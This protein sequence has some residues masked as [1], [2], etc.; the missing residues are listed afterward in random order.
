MKNKQSIFVALSLGVLI[1]SIIGLTT[2]VLMTNK[3][4]NTKQTTD[5]AQTDETSSSSTQGSTDFMPNIRPEDIDRTSEKE[6]TTEDSFVKEQPRLDTEPYAADITAEVPANTITDTEIKKQP[7]ER[8][9]NVMYLT[10][11][12]LVYY[13]KNKTVQV[14]GYEIESVT[15][16]QNTGKLIFTVKPDTADTQALDNEEAVT[17]LTDFKL[18]QLEPLVTQSNIGLERWYRGAD[19]IVFDIKS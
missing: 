10:Y 12:N 1:L 9:Y 16:Q 5:S 6:E 11:G 3:A 2:Y 15:V 18:T 7:S 4:D 13:L 8:D 19:S 14:A 17:R